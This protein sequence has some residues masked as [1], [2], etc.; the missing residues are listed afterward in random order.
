MGEYSNSIIIILLFLL[1][2][3]WYSQTKFKGKMLCYFLRPNKQRIKKW[4]P[5]YSRH[6]EFDRGKYGIERY[7]VIPKCIVLE[8]WTG[9]VNKLFPTLV[10]TLD[11]RWDTPNPKDP[12]TGETY[13]WHTPEVEAA[14]YRGHGYVAFTRAAAQQAGAKRNKLSEMIP[15]IVLGVLIIA[16]YIGYQYLGSLSDQLGAVQQQLNLIK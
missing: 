16:C 15:L 6:I 14:G 13:T 3:F 4:V 11:F 5:L 12:E 7:R 10:P 8:W 1:A 2:I 9:G